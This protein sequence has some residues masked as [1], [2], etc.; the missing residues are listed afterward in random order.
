MAEVVA[1]GQ[2]SAPRGDRDVASR[3]G[4]LPRHG[5]TNIDKMVPIEILNFML[6]LAERGVGDVAKRMHE[7]SDQVVCYAIANGLGTENRIAGVRTQRCPCLAKTGN[8]ALK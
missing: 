7:T 2:I 4:R 5:H 6:A 1:S 3:S 8:F